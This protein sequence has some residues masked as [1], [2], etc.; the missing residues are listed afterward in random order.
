MNTP[1]DGTKYRGPDRR[2]RPTSAWDA[3]RLRGRRMRA[4][5][6]DEHRSHYFVDRYTSVMF[7]GIV[8][9]LLLSIADGV[10]TLQLT[11][12]DY[13]E[14]NPVMALLLEQGHGAFFVGKYLL[15]VA[16]LPFLLI[17][18]NYYLFGSSFRVGY[19]IPC[20]VGAYSALL[21]YQLYLVATLSA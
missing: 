11:D 15:T 1:A 18:K 4:R 3:F 19:L 9:L 17:F 10:I 16:G 2:K 6:E 14:L 8:C 5:R 13:K 12:V 21:G 20:F 7:I